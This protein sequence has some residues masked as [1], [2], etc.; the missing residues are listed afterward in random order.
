MPTIH[1]NS[2][3]NLLG[4]GGSRSLRATLRQLS[5][6]LEADSEAAWRDLERRSLL[7]NPFTSSAFV[8][9]S[10]FAC[11]PRESPLLL[12][13]E[14]HAGR[15]LAAGVFSTSNGNRS[16]PLPHLSAL[17]FDHVFKTS[18][19][20]DAVH[21]PTV[22]ESLLELL[23]REG[24]HGL[25]FPKFPIGSPLSL[26]LTSACDAAGLSTVIDDAH[27][28]A[29]VD[30]RESDTGTGISN[31]RAKSMRRGRRYLEARG[32]VAFRWR[33]C[34][35]N[36]L[37]AAEQFLT[38][39][40]MGWKGAARTALAS[41][42]E[43]AN[44]FRRLVTTL[45]EQD[46]I[47]FAECLLDQQVIASACLF[48]SE[49][50]YYVFKLG[51][52]PVYER[53]GPGYLLAAEIR[54][55]ARELPGCRRIDGCARPGSFLEHVWS[56]RKL[57]GDALFTTTKWGAA[58]AQG[59]Q[60]ARSIMRLVRGGGGVPAADLMSLVEPEAELEVRED[61]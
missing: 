50:D 5:T 56:D 11:P 33:G 57:I 21:A 49:A 18:L 10:L 29:M 24:W 37:S 46:R 23:R 8:S 26:L 48:R 54:Q 14:D 19:L 40:A 27:Q 17:P 25:Q 2:P 41:Q 60:W 30:A 52:N 38:L 44:F 12:T 47:F 32:N 43:S 39:E 45:G 36:D 7:A 4:P 1:V 28:R 61:A 6:A 34:R 22:V 58:A 16:L 55:R 31:A 35:N 9:S 51:W 59:T 53:A 42:G 20:I 15:W 13:V 3:A